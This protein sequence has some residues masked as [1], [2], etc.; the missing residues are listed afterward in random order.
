VGSTKADIQIACERRRRLI[1]AVL[2]LLTGPEA[3][4]PEEC[5]HWLFVA[6]MFGS[7]KLLDNVI[8]GT[9]NRPDLR[10]EL[11]C[12]LLFDVMNRLIQ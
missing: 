2:D 9:T 12:G 10:E 4:T 7:K 3:P 6:E 1:D 8:V 11:L 5:Y